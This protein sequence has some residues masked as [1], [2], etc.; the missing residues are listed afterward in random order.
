MLLGRLELHRGHLDRP[1]LG[2]DLRALLFPRGLGKRPTQAGRRCARSAA[3]RRDASGRPERLDPALIPRRGGHQQMRRHALGRRALLRQRLGRRGVPR[4]ALAGREILVQGRANDRMNESQALATDE[5]VRP[6][7]LIRR[8]TGGVLAQPRHPADELQLAV[9][10]E[11][12][13]RPRQLGRIR[14]ERGKPM[15]DEAAHGRGTDRLHLARRARRR[16]D[17]RRVQRAEQLPQEQGIAA[18]GSVARAAEL[19]GRLR[20]EALPR[21]SHRGGLAQRP[22]L[23]HARFG[24]RRHLRPQRPRR[25]P[26]LNP[27]AVQRAASRPEA[28]RSAAPGRPGTAASRDRPTGNRRPTRATGRGRRGSRPA[29]RGCAGPRS[30]HRHSATAA[31]PARTGAPPDRPRPRTDRRA[32]EPRRSWAPAAGERC[33]TQ[34]A[35]RAP[36]LSPRAA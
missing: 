7:E 1:E 13:D 14:T 17:P 33:R 21:Q 31:R 30:R 15:Q 20:A 4:L 19:L 22:Q 18:G 12:G 11:H 2:Q 10:A 5:D 32:R 26:R 36:S 25:R 27:V 3:P 8:R 16:S 28:P 24:T 34:T 23:Q 6:D 29:S 35:A 9:V